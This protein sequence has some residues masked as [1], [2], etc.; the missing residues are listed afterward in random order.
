MVRWTQPGSQQSRTSIGG[1]LTCVSIDGRMHLQHAHM[2][3]VLP[4]L[5]YL[6]DG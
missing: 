2:P 3:S 4:V 6:P 5:T 1:M